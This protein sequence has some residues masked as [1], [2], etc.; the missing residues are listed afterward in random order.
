M[1]PNSQS[2]EPGE[3]ASARRKSA[4]KRRVI[5]SEDEHSGGADEDE[6]MREADMEEQ[7][8]AAKRIR[9]AQSTPS[10]G[11]QV[12]EQDANMDVDIDGLDN[13][14][15]PAASTSKAKGK[16]RRSSTAF[17]GDDGDFVAGGDD[18]DD[19]FRDAKIQLS[20]DD[21]DPGLPRAHS[22]PVR[23]KI[24][25][26]KVRDGEEQSAPRKPAKKAAPAAKSAK[27]RAA[28]KKEKEKETILVKDERK[29]V[30]PPA[31]TAPPKLSRSQ[32]SSKLAKQRSKS[33]TIEEPKDEDA[34]VDIFDEPVAAA[35]PKQEA[36]PPPAPAPAPVAVP[37]KKLPTIRKN[38]PAA[39]GSGTPTAGKAGASNPTNPDTKPLGIAV[40]R[41]AA[42]S[43]FD[44]R[45]KG[46][47]ASIFKQSGGSTPRSGLSRRE[48][49]EERRKELYKMRDEAR[50]KRDEALRVTFDLQA[51]WDKISTF[52]DTLK[53]QR[54]SVL[55]PNIFA[56]KFRDEYERNKRQKERELRPR[57]EHDHDAV[58]EGEMMP[59]DEPMAD[60]SN[61]R[62]RDERW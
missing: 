14:P 36:S 3:P 41:P 31:T 54:S 26:W 4:T 28:A 42:T 27:G 40:P 22:K 21:F 46:A 60:A 62:R 52:E 24:A 6:T 23:A 15:L 20:D 9:R 34:P 37:K 61:N 30:E 51:Q 53:Q 44:L 18:D 56:A 16:R 2:P 47:W 1:S 12:D 55:F 11:M 59:I 45:D 10:D 13:V 17:S 29:Q 32:S 49:E 48:K 5:E 19:N 57:R 35:S 58:E 39:S 38:K 8:P 25:T 50:A 43:D 7:R 33:Q